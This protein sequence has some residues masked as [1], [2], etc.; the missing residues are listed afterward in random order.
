MDESVDFIKNCDERNV[1]RNM[2][3]GCPFGDGCS[4]VHFPCKRFIGPSATL[5]RRGRKQCNFHELNVYACNTRSITSKTS[6]IR[7]VLANND[8]DVC[9]LSELNTRKPPKFE[10]YLKPFCK[11]SNQA[12][13]GIAIYVKNHLKG[14]IIRIPDEN[15]DLEIVHLMIKNTNPA[16]HIIG[17]YLDCE[18]RVLV[19]DMEVTWHKLVNKVNSILGQGEAVALLGDFNRAIDNPKVTHG[20]KLLIEWLQDNT[21]TLLN[22]NTYTR[23]A[24]NKKEKDSILDLAIVSNNISKCVESF[25]VDSEKVITPF[26]KL[27]S[28]Q[29]KYSDHR[30]ILVKLVMPSLKVLIG[31]PLFT[32]L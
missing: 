5:L 8:I 3:S 21:L 14:N 24:P 11:L 27:R 15:K 2:D 30:P 6:S 18:S 22:S 29:N 28:G 25:K 7:T 23:I 12:F 32:G 4:R 1:G 26:Y 16:L 13:H 19:D 9:I 20:K 31:V 17:V 10:G